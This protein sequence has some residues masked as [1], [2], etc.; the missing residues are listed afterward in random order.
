[1]LAKAFGQK[2]LTAVWA[3]LLTKGVFTSDQQTQFLSLGTG[4]ILACVS[5]G[6]SYF[7]EKHAKANFVAALNAPAPA[8]VVTVPATPTLTA[9]K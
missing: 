8:V 9:V 5:A 2:A 7:H 3:F 6:W 4:A 1:M